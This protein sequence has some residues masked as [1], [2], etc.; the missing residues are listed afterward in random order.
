[1]YIYMLKKNSNKPIYISYSS[2]LEIYKYRLN[3]ILVKNWLTPKTNL[4]RKFWDRNSTITSNLIE[5]NRLTIRTG[6]G[7]K[8]F[9][10]NE[11]NVGFK[12]GEFTWTRKPWKKR[13]KRRPQKPKRR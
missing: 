2:L 1:M 12:F 10:V 9:K 11:W 4:K 13:L 8:K 3:K 5:S 6:N 7:W